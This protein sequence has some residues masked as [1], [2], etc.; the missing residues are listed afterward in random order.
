MLTPAEADRADCNASSEVC[1]WLRF[2]SSSLPCEVLPDTIPGVNWLIPAVLP[3][4]RAS[5]FRA[6]V[7]IVVVEKDVDDV[8]G[9]K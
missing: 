9:G 2:S 7:A 5:P 3:E 4:R 1:P 8:L 6:L